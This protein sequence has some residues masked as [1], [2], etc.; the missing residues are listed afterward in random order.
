MGRTMASDPL[1]GFRFKVEIE[2]IADMGFTEATGLN[3]QTDVVE[4]REGGYSYTRKLPG[5]QKVSNVT[6]SRGSVGDLTLYNWYAMSLGTNDFRKTVT[7][8]EQDRNGVNKRAWVLHE[9]WAA[10][11]DMPTL[12]A[13]SD[14]VNVD[15]LVLEVEWIEAKTF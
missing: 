7:I 9:C 10:Q 3:S 2:G 15:K 1:Q 13:E 12:N 6:L 8:Y 11:F 14:N 4:Y 5:R